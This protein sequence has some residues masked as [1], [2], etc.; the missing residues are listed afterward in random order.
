MKYYNIN[1]SKTVATLAP[2]TPIHVYYKYLNEYKNA[3]FAVKYTDRAHDVCG[4]LY[5]NSIDWN[6]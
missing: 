1:D 6:S 2:H 5:T 3:R 4:Y